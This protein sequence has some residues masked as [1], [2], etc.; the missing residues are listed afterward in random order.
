MNN[1]Y[2][3]YGNDYSLIKKEIDKIAKGK[4]DVLRYDLSEVNVEEALDEASCASLFGD[5]KVV[6]GENALFLTSNSN[7]I[8]HNLDYLTKY[9]NYEN[10]DNILILSAITDKLD[11]RKKIVKLI[12][13]KSKVIH[14]DMIDEK[15]LPS[16]VIEE[17][18]SR[19]F[20]ISLKDAN[21]FVSYVGKNVDIINSEIDKM[22]IYKDD[23]VV[24]SK[25]IDDISSKALN[26][27]IFD[28]TDAIMKKDY[29]KMF[30]CY[31]DLIK[32]GEEP[33]KIIALLGS[34]F[35]LIYQVKRYNE[36][37]KS[38]GEIAEML[39][40]HPYRVKL[41]LESDFLINELED[42]IKKLHKLDY[43]IKSG[44]IDKKLAL[45][46]FLLKL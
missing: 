40:V 7:G 13:E 16:F 10:H 12:K 25:D 30:D 32:I 22:T 6:I 33:I 3:I 42:L 35:I 45:Q 15:S 4:S 23:K 1:I 29:K 8:E 36:E 18:K 28:F 43:E 31:N 41:A 38:Q 5:A 11:E 46:D 24:T 26:D 34:Q 2:L 19:G 14:K 39:K 37:Y 9:V 44:K 21:Y 20:T 17:F 27:N